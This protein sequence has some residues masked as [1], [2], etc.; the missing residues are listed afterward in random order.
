M[1]VLV[2]VL[3]AVVVLMLVVLVYP[4]PSFSTRVCMC[5]HRALDTILLQDARVGRCLMSE[6][7]L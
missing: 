2:V 3:V 6:V 5:H 1:L 4:E 7:T